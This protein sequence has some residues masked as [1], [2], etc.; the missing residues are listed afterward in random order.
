MEIGLPWFLYGLSLSQSWVG[1][2]IQCS[3]FL[4]QPVINI[5]LIPIDAP[6][7]FWHNLCFTHLSVPPG[8]TASF[9]PVC[10]RLTH[11]ARE[12]QT[13]GPLPGHL[14]LHKSSDSHPSA[15][16]FHICLLLP[17][18]KRTLLPTCQLPCP[19]CSL[20]SLINLDSYPINCH[21]SH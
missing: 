10:S 5:C 11:V 12:Q 16:V 2:L 7:C 1:T 8:D 20:P 9:Q 18:L 3:S 19:W 15:Y 4:S 14:R 6:H 21:T 17:H 13:P